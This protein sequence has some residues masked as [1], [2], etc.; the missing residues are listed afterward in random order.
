MRAVLILLALAWAPAAS[1]PAYEFSR[2]EEVLVRGYDQDIME[3]FLSRD[4]RWL[5]FNNSN[6]PGVNTDLFYSEASP[7]GNF[8]YRGPVRGVNG[9]ELDA[10]ASLDSNGFLY[11]VTTRSYHQDFKTI[12][13]GRFRNG[14]VTDVEPV[15]G[16]SLAQPGQ[17]N[18]DAEIGPD[19]SKI[20]FADGRFD[21]G[22][23][24]RQ[25]DL[26]MAQGP[27][28]RRVSPNPFRAVNTEALE[29][30]PHVSPDELE[31]FFT[32]I[33]DG[34]PA[35]FRSSRS[36][37]S[38]S[39]EPATRITAAEGFVEAACLSPDGQMLYYHKRVGDRYRLYRLRRGPARPSGDRRGSSDASAVKDEVLGMEPPS[40]QWIRR[41]S[42]RQ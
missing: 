32:R 13:R 5:L 11:F 14:L 36:S 10:V 3:P 27:A 17:L 9:P 40:L 7:D 28:F 33:V 18:F 20:Y 26:A 8:D 4:G 16:I 25:A 35:L 31:L 22:P 29:Y 21:G 12:Y 30:A 37:A 34:Q 23:L 41:E 42:P 15:E 38:R 1:Q 19:G 6:A 24:P 39:W 2:P